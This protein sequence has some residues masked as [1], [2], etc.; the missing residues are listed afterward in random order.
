M[1]KL[2]LL[3]VLLS[4]IISCSGRKQVEKA[5]NSGN[6][7]RAINDALKKLETNKDKKR[8]QDYVYMLQDAYYKVVDRD[9]STINHLKKDNNPELNQDIYEKYVDLNTRQEAIKPVMPLVVNGKTIPFKFN[10]YSN[11]IVKWRE[12]TSDYLYEKGLDLLESENKLDIRE[13]YK[14][15]EYIES[16][17]PNYDD[18]RELLNEAHQRGLDHVIVTIK[19]HTNQIIPRRLE[20]DLL[21]FDTYG[22][23]KFWTA[24]HANEES[25]RKYDYAMQLQLKQ[26]NISPEQIKEREFLR[27]KEIVDGWEYVLD[28]NDNVKKDSLGNDIKVDKIIQVRARY[29]EIEQ[30]KSSQVIADVV[31]IDLKT[32]QTIDSFPIDSGFIFENIFG[33]FK[34]DKRALTREDREI[35]R[36]Q[37]IPFPSNEQMVYDTGEDLKIQLKKIINSYRIRS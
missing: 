14:T 34:G 24:Y 18:T 6:Y 17:N 25:N 19:N 1:K 27:K 5:L 28:R 2:L 10:D 37:Q 23:N 29:F 30:F 4:F 31:Y 7:D 8:K 11:E 16:I 13:A 35:A 9:L 32:N 20:D 33:T 36:N 21:N 15:Y 12:K 3:T 26:I 22:L